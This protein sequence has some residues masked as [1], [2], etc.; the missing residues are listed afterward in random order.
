ML[1]F[2]ETCADFNVTYLAVNLVQRSLYRSILAQET[3]T[4]SIANES[5][6]PMGDHSRQF[7]L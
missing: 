5:T 6:G 1:S 4:S 2:A 3:A 7:P